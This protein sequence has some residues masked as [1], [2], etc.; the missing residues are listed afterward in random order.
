M[1]YSCLRCIECGREY[2]LSDIRFTCTCGNLLDVSHD[3]Q[4][5]RASFDLSREQFG[6]HSAM[7]NGQPAG[8]V[9]RFRNMVLPGFPDEAIVSKQEG[10]TR[11][12]R[13]K[14]VSLWTGCRNL[15]LKHEGENPTGSFKDRGMTAAVTQARALGQR[16][17]TCASTGNTSA[18]LAAYASEAEI[19][20]L[21]L[22]PKGNVAVGKISQ[23]LAY[24]TKTL[25][26]DG[27]FDDCMRLIRE[28]QE[29]LGAYPLNSIN[30]FR[31]EGQKT[32]VWEALLQLRWRVPDWFV[33]P[34][35][36]LGNTSA[37]GKAL[38]EAVELGWIDKMPRFAVIQAQGASPFYEAFKN[39][40]STLRPQ[41][42]DTIA[43]A[44][45]I[46][47]PVN[48]SKAVRSLR[49][50]N[51]I[52]ESVT[53]EEILEAKAHVDAAGIGAEPASCATVAGLKK[54][55]TAGIIDEGETVVGILTGNILKDPQ[56]IVDYHFA[57]THPLANP[58]VEIRAEIGDVEK[59]LSERTER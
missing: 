33:F 37:F 45:K 30:P 54:L 38:H 35:G 40:F 46:G 8:G 1:T 5:V 15:F 31:L 27:D 41:K 12:Y 36:N 58:P 22:I 48:Y 11:L 9:W 10:N 24:G 49:W 55:V 23:A 2:L 42:A 56:S 50:T 39:G 7:L 26:V 6:E 59:I 28:A 4:S 3:W 13:S 19:A 21:V 20:G 44:I 14:K 16:A 57:K 18:S 17:V 51:G 29:R 25:V 43:T 32:I 53:D 47:N 34:G 52:V